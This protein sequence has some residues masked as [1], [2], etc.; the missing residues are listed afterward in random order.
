[1]WTIMLTT[2]LVLCVGTIL[3][4]LVCPRPIELDHPGRGGD[5]GVL[6]E[7]A[8]IAPST[9]TDLGLI[10]LATRQARPS[11]GPDLRP[12][13]WA[14]GLFGLSPTCCLTGSNGSRRGSRG[15]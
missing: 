14:G 1:M 10:A 2:P 12:D 7:A 13:P 11:R 4:A 9:S 15:T 8:T 3:L 5:A 6:T